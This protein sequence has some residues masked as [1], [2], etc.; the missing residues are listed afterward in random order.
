MATAIVEESGLKLLFLAFLFVGARPIFLR[1]HRALYR[2]L[3]NLFF[4]CSQASM[5][6]LFMLPYHLATAVI[7]DHPNGMNDTGYVTKDGQQD[8]NL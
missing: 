2:H 4:M 6:L 5:E 1:H 7:G 8:I 3:K